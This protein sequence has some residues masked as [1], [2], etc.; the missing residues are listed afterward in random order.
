[1]QRFAEYLKNRRI[2]PEKRIR[3]Y[4]LWVTKFHKFAGK[5]VGDKL[6]KERIAEFIS[7]IS[8]SYEDWQL[9]QASEAIGMY[10]Y[11][12]AAQTVHRR[13]SRSEDPDLW[14]V[15][16]KDLRTALRLK[17]RPAPSKHFP[18]PLNPLPQGAGKQSG[19]NQFRCVECATLVL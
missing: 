15:L 18:P 6:P 8:A 1:M 17:G 4:V 14:S 12:S 7:S 13:V 3:F 10:L 19:S 11:Y 5:R 2:V 9:K 16:M